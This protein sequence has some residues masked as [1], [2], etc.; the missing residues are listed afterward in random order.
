MHTQI[1]EAL[2][3]LVPLGIFL[4]IVCGGIWAF[5]RIAGIAFHGSHVRCCV[6]GS[7]WVS[8]WNYQGKPFCWPCADGRVDTDMIQDSGDFR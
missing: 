8:Y 7:R 1:V 6:C 5:A 2:R 4:I 3:S